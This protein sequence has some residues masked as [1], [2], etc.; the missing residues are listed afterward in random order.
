MQRMTDPTLEVLHVPGCPNL[1]RMLEQLREA[2]H[3]PVATH[4][5]TTDTYAARLGMAGSPTLL[6]NGTDPF[7]PPEG[8]DDGL[9]CRLYRDQHDR[10]VPS[11]SIE[12]LRSAITDVSHPF[13][14][15][16]GRPSAGSA[17]TT[18]RAG[19]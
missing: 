15:T 7:A 9:S 17:H 13:G 8:G 16:S 5:V 14:P 4:E 18:S 10:I 1:P 11:P 19:E 3:L 12:Q 2:T 6:V